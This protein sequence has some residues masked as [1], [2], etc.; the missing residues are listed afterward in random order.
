MTERHSPIESKSFGPEIVDSSAEFQL[1]RE[2]STEEHKPGW[3]VSLVTPWGTRHEISSH[4]HR[5]LANQKFQSVLNGLE[6]WGLKIRITGPA[7]AEI[8]YPED[9]KIVDN[10]D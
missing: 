4:T 3:A 10:L 8:I 2:D 1:I 6:N 9:Q 5:Q 7:T